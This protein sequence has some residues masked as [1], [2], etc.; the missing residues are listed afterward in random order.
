MLFT[1]RRVG[2]G[3]H[4]LHGAYAGRDSGVCILLLCL[5]LTI[6]PFRLFAQEPASTHEGPSSDSPIRPAE[7]LARAAERIAKQKVR[8]DSAIALRDRG[9]ALA[10]TMG[11]AADEISDRLNA[12]LRKYKRDMGDLSQ[13]LQSKDREERNA[14]KQKAREVKQQYRAEAREL[15][16]SLK[17]TRKEQR[18]GMNMASKG[19]A[20]LQRA[21]DALK[22]ALKHEKK[23][24]QQN[25]ENERKV[26]EY[27]KRRAAKALERGD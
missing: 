8:I 23:V 3:N 1:Q 20:R 10:K 26:I 5:L 6:V 13:A 25:I 11:D 7:R 17:Q 4:F 19:E 2:L 27:E 18:R 22:R 14:A 24:I 12:V 15:K 21:K 9:R 16:T